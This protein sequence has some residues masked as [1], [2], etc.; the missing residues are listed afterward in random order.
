VSL[1]KPVLLLLP[2]AAV[3]LLLQWSCGGLETRTQPDLCVCTPAVSPDEDFRTLAKHV[4]LPQKKAIEISVRHIL[5]FPR[6]KPPP[7]FEA[8]RTGRELN[9]YHVGNAFVQFVQ[10]MPG[11]CDIHIEISAS[12]DKDAPRVIVETPHTASYCSARHN[13]AA[14]LN[15]HGVVVDNAAWDL[16][17]PLPAEVLGLAFQDENHQRG[18]PQVATIWEL[19]PAIVTLK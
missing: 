14:Q 18:T 19:H 9:L 6:I 3:L 10:L 4:D 17:P 15:A 12:A 16:N 13:L 1:K 5:N 2:L 7:G 11:D 8:P